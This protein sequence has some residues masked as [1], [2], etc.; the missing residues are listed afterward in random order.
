MS[1]LEDNQ[2]MH[3]LLQADEAQINEVSSKLAA[4][5]RHKALT[6]AYD[7]DNGTKSGTAASKIY[8]N[9]AKKFDKYAR[10]KEEQEREDETRASLPMS[11]QRKISAEEAQMYEGTSAEDSLHP[12]ARAVSDP[13]ALS[14]SKIGMMNSLSG[15]MAGMSKDDCTRFFDQAMALIGK[16]ASYLSPNSNEKSNEASIRMKG[17]YAVGKSGP[18]A[19]MPM[20]MISVREDVEDMFEG[21]D[22]TEE[23]KEKVST[24]FEAAVSARV[25]TEQVRLEE[26]YAEILEEEVSEIAEELTNGLDTYLDYVVE[27]FMTENQV[28]IDST[29]R[30][31]LMDEFIGGLKN[32]FA[33]HYFDLPS[34]K[35]D[36]V[37]SLATKV[38]ELEDMLNG[39]IVENVELKREMVNTGMREVFVEAISGLALTQQ[40]R[41][42]ALAE[43]IEFDGDVEKY[44]RKLDIIKE[45]YF[46]TPKL[47]SNIMTES[48]EEPEKNTM[49]SDPSVSKYVQAIARTIKK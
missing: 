5:A 31:E 42:R 35:V 14:A 24:L 7:L 2:E 26:A 9:Q 3:E 16:E 20:P 1:N 43:G 40:E 39:V 45:T 32:L 33:E 15:Y 49:S 29:L 30:N 10:N 46:K 11:K 38:E 21:Q 48:F 23:F 19:N 22:L 36:V 41:F 13:K 17:S 27:Q 25:I 8:K 37:E 44:A 34:D 28:A 18:T 6:Q 12:A 47:E 4:R